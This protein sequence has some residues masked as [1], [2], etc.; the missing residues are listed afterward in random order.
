MKKAYIGVYTIFTIGNFFNYQNDRLSEHLNITG[1]GKSVRKLL[2]PHRNQE[3]DQTLYQ[4]HKL[5]FPYI[6]VP[7]VIVVIAHQVAQL[8]RTI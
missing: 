4:F 3:K 5:K 1:S 7:A 2:Y 8:L 6:K